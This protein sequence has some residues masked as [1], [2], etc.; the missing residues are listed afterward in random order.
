MSSS[1]KRSDTVRTSSN[2]GPPE[3]IPVVPLET[4][5]FVSVVPGPICSCAEFPLRWCPGS[6]ATIKPVPGRVLGSGSASFSALAPD[7]CSSD[8]LS[9]AR[10][11]LRHS[12][13]S[14]GSG[15][16][17]KSSVG[18]SSRAAKLRILRVVCILAQ[19]LPKIHHGLLKNDGLILNIMNR[20]VNRSLWCKHE[21]WLHY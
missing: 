9:L 16:D 4:F 20:V 2:S 3:T 11:G 10:W 18:A 7:S 15:V 21:I 14:Y 13:S 5:G 12:Y 8:S 19:L 1:R 6:I 17:S